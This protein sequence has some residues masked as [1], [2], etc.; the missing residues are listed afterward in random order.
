M[1]SRLRLILTVTIAVLAAGCQTIGPGGLQRDRMDYADAI[2]ASWRQQTLLNIVKLRY[3][4]APVFL[5]VSS[6]I[7]S[8]TLQ[9]EVS[10]AAQHFP[11][12]SSSSTAQT[13][14]RLGLTGTYTDHP[15]ISYT[16]VTGEKYIEKL[17]RPIPPQAIFAMLQAGH[18]AD[19]ILSLSVRAINDSFNYSAGPARKRR[20]DPAF[21]Q[22]IDAFHRIQQAGALGV[23]VEKRGKEEVTFIF[24]PEKADPEVEK[25]IRN[26]KEMLGIKPEI[27]ELLLTYGAVR[28]G[29]GEIAVLTRSMWEILAELSSG[30]DIPEQDS[31][32]GRAVAMPQSG[33]RAQALSSA[34][35]RSSRERPADAYIAARYRDY[36]FWIDD[37]DLSSKRLFAFLM[38]FSSIAETGA[39]PQIPVITIP[40]N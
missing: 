28:R 6:I 10:F 2:A 30:V 18:P 11:F 7:G 25:D 14:Q 15:T 16:P 32:E 24:F 4:D 39:V 13:N 33:E 22:I 8:Y 34:H 21:L 19:Y 37:R 27:K 17:L 5:E 36:W 20:E 29:S 1:C 38:V 26:L 9:S 23:R 31:A 35:I 40:A 3:F 12:V